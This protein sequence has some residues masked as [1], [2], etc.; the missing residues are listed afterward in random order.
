M[1]DPKEICNYLNHYFAN[2][3]RSIE[4]SCPQSAV[5]FSQYLRGDFPDF[6]FTLVTEMDVKKVV[7]SRRVSG[8][9]SDDVSLR[10]IKD[11]IDILAPTITSLINKS[12]TS[13]IYPNDLKIAK[14]IPIFKGGERNKMEN[15]RQISILN[16]MNKIFEKIVYNQLLD[17]ANQNNIFTPHQFGFLK[18]MST[19]DALLNFLKRIN[20]NLDTNKYTFALFLDLAKAFD[21]LNHE[22]LLEKLKFYGIRN[23]SLAWVTSY[24]SNRRQYLVINGHTSSHVEVTHGVP[25][26]SILGPLLFLFFINDFPLCSELMS[27]TQFADD[28]NGLLAD[29]DLFA[30]RELAIDE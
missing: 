9:G 24:L 16:A 13:G 26:G 11:G 2:V 22:I 19:Q 29:S 5:H 17:H 27:F 20:E 1:T 21:S 30:L 10:L 7:K 6:D 18:S 15:Y 8:P 25:Q 12:L 28:V 4:E 14:I 3:G 23:S